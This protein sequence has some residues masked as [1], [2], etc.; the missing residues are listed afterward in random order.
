MNRYFDLP[1]SQKEEKKK[2]EKMLP[3]HQEEKKGRRKHGEMKFT[4]LSLT[5]TTTQLPHLSHLMK[6]KKH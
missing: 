4:P 6:K 2:T 5:L 3:A 1:A